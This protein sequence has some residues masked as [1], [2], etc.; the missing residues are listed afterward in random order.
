[1]ALSQQPCVARGL[2][3]LLVRKFKVWGLHLDLQLPVGKSR[4]RK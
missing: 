2:C 3:C 4:R 1:M